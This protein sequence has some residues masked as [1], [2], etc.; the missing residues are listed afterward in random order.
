MGCIDR[1]R[2]LVGC[3][4]AVLVSMSFQ[5]I[6]CPV[7]FSAG[8]QQAMR[9]AIRIANE[10][11]AELVLFHAWCVPP[12]ALAGEYVFPPDLMQELCD[13]SRKA[14]DTAMH[15]AATLG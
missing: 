10:A 15:E 1:H 6:L 3:T 4:L 8:S 11:G 9:V 7:D 12:L 14:L 13:D 2:N 5:K